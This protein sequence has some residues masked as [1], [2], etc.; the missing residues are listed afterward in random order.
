MEE[1][2]RFLSNY[3]E[4]KFASHGGNSDFEWF[5]YLNHYDFTI[6][7]ES[8][9]VQ[10]EHAR[11]K[12]R[13]GIRKE[14]FQAIN[15]NAQ[16]R[17]RVKYPFVVATG[18]FA[19]GGYP[20]DCFVEALRLF[21]RTDDIIQSLPSNATIDQV[22]KGKDLILPLVHA[23]SEALEFLKYKAEEYSKIGCRSITALFIYR[24][25]P[26][27]DN[28]YPSNQNYPKFTERNFAENISIDT[29]LDFIGSMLKGI[30]ESRNKNV[31]VGGL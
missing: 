25:K 26:S 20:L 7:K 12:H 24:I 29:K 11:M 19:P 22:Y 9:E 18:Q 23:D 1:D 31:Y 2:Y 30:E 4:N 16:F 13:Y 28:K 15:N 6:H 14:Y 8:S 17:K 5:A 3:D 27:I 10:K 21:F